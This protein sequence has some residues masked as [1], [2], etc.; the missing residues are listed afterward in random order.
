M[1]IKR[2][3]ENNM[4]RNGCTVTSNY[5]FQMF[6]VPINKISKEAEADVQRC[7]VK[8]VLLKI[9]QNSQEDICKT[10]LKINFKINLKIDSN[11]VVFFCESCEI[12][13]T[14]FFVDAKYSLPGQ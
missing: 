8:K 11:T 13:N 14:I 7:S 4:S 1:P 12:F 3:I 9:S 6:Q 5:T 2:Y 10:D